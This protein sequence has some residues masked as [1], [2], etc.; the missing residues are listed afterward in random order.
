M[1]LDIN[2]IVIRERVFD[3]LSNSDYSTLLQ[4]PEWSKVKD[5]WESSYF[6]LENNGQ[7]IAAA[8]LLSRCDNLTN[9]DFYYVPNGPICRQDDFASME[10][11]IT[12]MK[13][14]ARSKGGFLLRV[15]PRI[16]FD[17]KLYK[18][19]CEI[20]PLR[21]DADMFGQAPMS[22]ILNFKD[23]S[24]EQIFSAYSKNMRNNIK[25]PYKKNLKIY[26]GTREDLP[27]FY[28]MLKDMSEKKGIGIRPYEY[29][30][31]IYDVFQNK[32]RL[33]F[34]A[35]DEINNGGNNVCT[36]NSV[37]P[38]CELRY[39]KMGLRLLASSMLIIHGKN[40][41]SLYGADPIYER[42]GQSY[43]LDF[44]EIR[45]ACEMGCDSY[46]MGGVYYNDEA[47]GL[48]SFKNRM[49]Q[50]GLIK[51]IG[52]FECVLDDEVYSRYRQS[53]RECD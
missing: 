53:R 50:N 7:I 11:L 19:Y 49:T 20:F 32:L 17:E 28:E 22:T 16:E 30:E 21:N 40:A 35:I 48:Y 25:S 42:L 36:S 44:E 47:D 4:L 24:I 29:F 8:L 18:Q 51:W 13:E 43:L 31:K 9:R 12:E 1:L 6:Y 38:S 3:F 15:E 27:I 2:N 52:V 10:L 46:D 23:R 26:I 41:I 5:N 45:Y 14:Y 33:S 37:V 39:D 34:V